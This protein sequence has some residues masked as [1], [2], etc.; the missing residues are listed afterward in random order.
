[1]K[2]G[3]GNGT[4]V[5]MGVGMRGNNMAAPTTNSEEETS[6]NTKIKQE[7]EKV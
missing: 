2:K 1:M 4:M 3:D 7:K 6:P 5:G